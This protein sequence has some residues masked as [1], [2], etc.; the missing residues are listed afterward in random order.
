[1]AALSGATSPRSMS[2]GSE[3]SERAR[4]V[5]PE[6]GLP[7]DEHEPVVGPAEAPPGERRARKDVARR[8]EL[9]L[10]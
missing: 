1:M 10:G 5:V 2:P 7:D 3:P 6:R 8:A 4:N 9:E